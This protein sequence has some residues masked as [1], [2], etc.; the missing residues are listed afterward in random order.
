MR[1]LRPALLLIALVAASGFAAEP[2]PPVSLIANGSLEADVNADHW[3]DGWARARDGVQWHEEQGN[4][5]LR[6]VSGQPGETV[7]LYHAVKLPE[8]VRALT[9]NWRMRCTD[10]KPGKQPWFDARILLEFKDAAGEKLPG[11]PS[12]PYS[13]RNTDGWVERS[14]SILVPDG[15]RTLEFMPALLQVERGVFDLDDVV[16]TST[17]P[18]PLR[19]AARAAA[20]AT[21]E[22]QAQAAAQRRAR[23]T[24]SL[25]KDGSLLTNG[26]FEADSDSDGWPDHWGRL[27]TGGHWESEAEP[28]NHFLR[29]KS[30]APGQMI[31][32][33]RAIDL[34]EGAEALELSWRQRTS[35]LKPGKEP[36]FDARIMLEFKDQAGKKLSQK[37]SPPYTRSNTSDWIDRRIQ[38]LVPQ[39]A[40][41]LEFMPALFQVER[42]TFDLDDIVLKPTDPAPLIAAA[43]AAAEAEKLARVPPEDPQ[44]ARWPPELHVVGNRILTPQDKPVWLQGVNVVSLEFS[45]KGEQVLKSALVAVEDWKSNA[46]RLPVKE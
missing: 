4:H 13:R 25:Q 15:A 44:P 2:T 26:S 11:G 17:D 23:A 39:G 27:K 34:P 38:F 5:F 10:L 36:Y 16:L 33:Y 14:I 21:A 19:E 45:A 29:L 28:A 8:E 24:A 35:D 20:A 31:L 7:L 22:K 32:L 40:L 42:G 6:L 46:I 3:P 9:L 43:K 30:P 1:S 41:S 12:A 18:V 37:P